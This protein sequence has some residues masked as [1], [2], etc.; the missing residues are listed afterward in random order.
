MKFV[1][2]ATDE[3]EPCLWSFAELY[4]KRGDYNKCLEIGLNI[5]NRTL[6][7]QEWKDSPPPAPLG[8]VGSAYRALAKQAK[9]EKNTEEAIKY[10]E[11][12][13]ELGVATENDLKILNNLR[14]TAK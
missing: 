12:M 14:D 10:F 6:S 2:D 1:Y 7:S 9:K 13:E 11:L 3:Y 5:H 8:I 4:Y